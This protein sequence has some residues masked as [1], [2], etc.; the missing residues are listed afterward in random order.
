[1]KYFFVIIFSVFSL[2]IFSQVKPTGKI[3]INKSQFVKAKTLSEFIS[4]LPKDCSIDG[5][6][7]SIDTPQLRKTLSVKGNKISADLKSVVKGM[8]SGQKFF[9]E[10]VK[11]KCKTDFKKSYIFV[12]I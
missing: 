7:F 10:N 2:A 6:Q 3:K 5:Y 1:M 12:I 11:S 4:S 9:I 8:Q